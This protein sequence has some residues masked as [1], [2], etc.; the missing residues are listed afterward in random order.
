[1]APLFISN[2]FKNSDITNTHPAIEKRIEI[3]ER[4]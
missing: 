3:L 4:M 1:M 2:P